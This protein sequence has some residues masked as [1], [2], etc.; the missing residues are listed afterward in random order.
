M[1]QDL[2]ISFDNSISDKAAS[3]AADLAEVSLDAV[4]DDGLLKDV[5]IISTVI[6]LYNIGHSVKERQYIRKFASFIERFNKGIVSEEQ[7]DYYKSKVRDDTNQR[8]KEIEYLLILIDRYVDN[9]KAE[10]LAKLFLAYLDDLI[11]WQELAKYAEVLDQIL[12]GDYQELEK[13]KWNDIKNTDAS[14][15]LLRL[16]SL[17]L[18]VSAMKEFRFENGTLTAPDFNARDYM[19]SPFGEKLLDCLG[20]R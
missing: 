5:P 13:Q 10:K 3:I 2:V 6:G 12:P 20:E 1:N 15:S 8:S 18:V 17:G 16:S 14:D 19:L 7:R 11:S 4:L 9:D